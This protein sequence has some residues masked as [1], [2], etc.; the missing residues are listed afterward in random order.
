MASEERPHPPSERRRRNAWERGLYPVT[1]DL[2]GL[3]LLVMLLVA[4]QWGFDPAMDRARVSMTRLWDEALPALARYGLET[5]PGPQTPDSRLRAPDSGPRTPG[6]MAETTIHRSLEAIALAALG[7]AVVVA[8]VPIL[9]TGLQ[10][11]LRLRPAA[12]AESGGS[13]EPSGAW[14]GASIALRAAIAI[15]VGLLILRFAGH[16]FNWAGAAITESGPGGWWVASV[17]IALA[18]LCLL[19]AVDYA[20]RRLSFERSL[21]MTRSEAR[22]EQRAA[23]PAPHTRTRVRSRL[24][25]HSGLAAATERVLVVA[26]PSAALITFCA[27][28]RVPPQLVSWASGSIARGMEAAA[29]EQGMRVL[30]RPELSVVLT[31]VSP[32]SILTG[33]F[34][35]ALAE[36]H[37]DIFGPTGA[38]DTAAPAP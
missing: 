38:T 32:R 26:G 25:R 35:E 36:V 22:A 18:G 30:E 6:S 23:E 27:D 8:L 5:R 24:T 12:M 10:R 20:V 3:L 29:R 31:D 15:G 2:A 11:G 9:A 7:L 28:P 16:R 19:A 14:E 13:R 33:A 21:W 1:P 4:L 34:I 17:G 37:V